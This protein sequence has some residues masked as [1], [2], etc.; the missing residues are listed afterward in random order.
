[1]PDVILRRARADEAA[2]VAALKRDTFRE[3]FLSEGF[4][5][6]YPPEDLAAF[7]AQSC[8]TEAV[9]AQLLD[10]EKATW[11]AAQDRALLGYAGVGPCRLPHPE[12]LPEHG[13]LYQLYVRRGAQGLG[14]GGGLLNLALGH[15]ATVR[16][17]PVWLG[18]WSGNTRAQA[19]YAARG[20]LKVGE[21]PFPVG[22]WRD[23]EW[24]M[25]RG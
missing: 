9:F 5:I 12:V 23:D 18:V 21:Y 1:M 24:I 4:G 2:A 20:F 14:L 16:P 7:E 8:S 22:A 17:G 3:T 11:V 25:R 19:V 6:P 10:P 13:E 15:L